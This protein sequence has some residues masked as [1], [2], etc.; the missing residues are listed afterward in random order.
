[1]F[2]ESNIQNVYLCANPL[3]GLMVMKWMNEQHPSTKINRRFDVKQMV[4][5]KQVQIKYV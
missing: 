4:F 1:M 3:I 2:S 5:T